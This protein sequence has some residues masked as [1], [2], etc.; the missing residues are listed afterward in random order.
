LVNNNDDIVTDEVESRLKDL[1][2]D[3]D[4]SPSF[5][6]NSGESGK[7]PVRE[8]EELTAVSDDI[9][10]KDNLTPGESGDSPEFTE[11]KD[12]HDDSALRYLKAIVLSID[13]EINDETMKGLIDETDRL[14]DVY[15][16]DRTFVLLFQLLGSVGKYIKTNKAGAH[17]DSITLLNSIYASLEKVVLSES[18]TEAARKKELFGQL[19]KF[20]QL[21]ERIGLTKEGT[22]KKKKVTSHG[23]PAAKTG[24]RSKGAGLQEESRPGGETVQEVVRSDMSRML[25]HEAFAFALEEI[26]E[27]IKVEFKA[28]R[29]ELKLWRDGE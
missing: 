27:V 1:F 26:K 7:A 29:A 20:K 4:E 8:L 22:A 12:D 10:K 2:G 14:K 25:P 11:D 9:D 13:W 17:P 28:L 5:E 15:E 16:D 24:E 3:G 19:K 21:K 18:M 23:I 6:G